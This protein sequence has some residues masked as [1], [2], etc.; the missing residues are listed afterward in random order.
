M[1]TRM[2][3]LEVSL[4]CAGSKPADNDIFSIFWF[5]FTALSLRHC[6]VSPP[7]TC[8]RPCSQKETV[9]ALNGNAFLTQNS[10]DHPFRISILCVR[11]RCTSRGPWYLHSGC[12]YPWYPLWPPGALL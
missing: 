10:M 3:S 5:V 6:C 11:R 1:F 12:S 9:P 7:T 4:D 8:S 2:V